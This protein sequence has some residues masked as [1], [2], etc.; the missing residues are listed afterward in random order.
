[1]TTSSDITHQPLIINLNFLGTTEHRENTRNIITGFHE[2]MLAQNNPH[3]ISRL[4]DGPGSRPSSNNSKH[5]IPGTYIYNP[6]S[7]EKIRISA[8]ISRNVDDVIKRL[9]GSLVGDGT[10]YL[11][12]EAILFINKTIKER[13]FN[14]KIDQKKI[15]IN[16]HGFSRG[17]DSCV[18]MAN[19]LDKLYPDI[20]VNL[21]LI[22][23]VPGPTK[24]HDPNS[25]TIPANVKR[26][27]SVFM[28][29]EYI[30]GFD[31]QDDNRLVFVAP[32]VT[33]LTYTEYFGNHGQGM[34]IRKND[35]K[36]HHI[37]KLLHDDMYRFCKDTGSLSKDAVSPP[38]AIKGWSLDE[39]LPFQKDNQQ[40][41]SAEE[42]FQLYGDMKQNEAAYSKGPKLSIRPILT[43][44]QESIDSCLFVNQEHKQLFKQLY[45]AV[46]N[47]FF[48]GNSEKM[49]SDAVISQL[50]S[51]SSPSFLANFKT[52]SQY[53]ADKKLPEPCIITSN[54]GLPKGV[55][56]V[57]NELTRLTYSLRAIVNYYTYHHPSKDS[58][59]DKAVA[60]IQVILKKAANLSDEEAV[61]YI[62]QRIKKL[63]DFCRYY[64]KHHDNFIGERLTLM[65][66]HPMD[67][68]RRAIKTIDSYLKVFIA[69]KCLS[70]SQIESISTTCFRIEEIAANLH[71]SHHAKYLAIQQ[72]VQY[73]E[74]YIKPIITNKL[75]AS[76][77]ID[78]HSSDALNAFLHNLKHFSQQT[79][80]KSIAKHTIEKLDAYIERNNF[81]TS[82]QNLFKKINIPFPARFTPEKNTIAIE[83]KENLIQLERRGLGNDIVKLNLQFKKTEADLITLY[84]QDGIGLR[85]GTLDKIMN[86]SIGALNFFA[87]IHEPAPF[88]GEDEGEHEAKHFA[89]TI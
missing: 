27:N 32:D 85:R 87:S 6:D 38:Y 10:D 44:Y 59:N 52:Y 42:R 30:P 37:T 73:L 70:N 46:F 50:N 56:L 24:M 74:A 41:L 62:K 36:R 20:D 11:L 86:H 76:I 18:R 17:A 35:D 54:T 29:H 57:T 48:E 53:D 64:S 19:I 5:P 39:Q 8:N 51:I 21:L 60:T 69:S 77:N 7:D 40:G 1:M 14:P 45:P 67:Y 49:T 9:T 68:A 2:A 34:K 12:F 89:S 61:V 28:L 31:I 47:W 65:A 63:T 23:Q 15:V 88:E 83:L 58:I 80:D 72:S 16:L 22:D 43:R 84:Q 66:Y 13:S 82:I 25:Y 4:F 75:A 55:P 26:L 78:S 33:Q 71:L 79:V 81:W 3:I